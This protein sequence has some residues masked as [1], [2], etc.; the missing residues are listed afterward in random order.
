MGSFNVS[1]GLSNLTIRPGDPVVYIPLKVSPES[2]TREFGSFYIYPTAKFS[3][4]LPSLQG[5]YADYGHVEAIQEG[6]ATSLIR[7]RFHLSPEKFVECI[8]NDNRDIY[9]EFGPIAENF[10]NTF[11]ENSYLLRGDMEPARHLLT[12]VGFQEPREGTF[13]WAR[14]GKEPEISIAISISREHSSHW[15][16]SALDRHGEVKW[17][18]EYD[19]FIGDAGRA[20]DAMAT[21]FNVYPGFQEKHWKAIQH[22]RS[23]SG[24]YIHGD[25]YEEMMKLHLP[26]AEHFLESAEEKLSATEDKFK[27]ID[28]KMLNKEKMSDEDRHE[29]FSASLVA[30]NGISDY[31]QYLG[32]PGTPGGSLREMRKH[33]DAAGAILEMLRL[34]H[35]MAATNRMFTP[36]IDSGFEVDEDAME[37]LSGLTMDIIKAREEESEEWN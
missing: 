21:A 18:K 23:M 8:G 13:T 1:C 24:M 2:S 25:V 4:C 36:G 17:S 30:A 28:V 26:E 19:A 32:S 9:S 35:V 34:Y 33:G 7:E 14:D 27:V 5:V 12:G 10:P 37:K 29:L 6:L 16:G 20:L 22:L 11:P 15:V 3:Q 31:H